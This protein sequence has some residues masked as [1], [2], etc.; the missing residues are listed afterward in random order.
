MEKDILASSNTDQASNAI[1]IAGEKGTCKKINKEKQVLFS[2]KGLKGV[3][4]VF[5]RVIMST[6]IN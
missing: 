4:L 2:F 5:F 1:V 3:M 6:V